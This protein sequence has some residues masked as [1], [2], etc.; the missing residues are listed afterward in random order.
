MVG[1]K[2]YLYTKSWKQC[3]QRTQHVSNKTWRKR[4][5]NIHKICVKGKCT[6]FAKN[7]LFCFEMRHTFLYFFWDAFLN[8]CT[9][10]SC[11]LAYG[12]CI[13][14][15]ASVTAASEVVISSSDKYN[16]LPFKLAMKSQVLHIVCCNNNYFWWGCREIWHWS[17]LGVEA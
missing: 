12:V 10:K 8:F 13:F 15:K 16:H 14:S 6:S 17:Q 2:I 9:Q 5:Q 1:I 4:S 11:P 7:N 3:I